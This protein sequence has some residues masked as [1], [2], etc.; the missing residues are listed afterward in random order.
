LLQA[1]SLDSRP[2]PTHVTRDC[3]VATWAIAVG[4]TV[5]AT[6]AIWFIAVLM[7]AGGCYH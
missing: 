2:S 3:R 7:W 6:M 1:Q 5:L 4:M